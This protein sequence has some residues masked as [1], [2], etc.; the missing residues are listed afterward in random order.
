MKKLQLFGYILELRLKKKSGKDRIKLLSCML[1]KELK[2]QGWEFK[3][4]NCVFIFTHK[5]DYSVEM[6]SERFE[7]QKNKKAEENQ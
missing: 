1:L 5:D 3:D 7:F 6:G 2:E 4:N